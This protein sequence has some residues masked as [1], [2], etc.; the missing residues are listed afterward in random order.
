MS[1]QFESGRC[2]SMPSRAERNP[3]IPSSVSTGLA[4]LSS[5]GVS[6]AT[7]DST[8]RHPFQTRDASIMAPLNGSMPTP[9]RRGHHRSISH[10]FTS[11]FTAIG[12]KREKAAQKH[13]TWDSDSDSD[14]VTYPVQPISTSPRK[15]SKG[16]IGNELAEGRCQTCNSTVRWPRHLKVFRCTSCLMVTDLDPEPQKEVKSPVDHDVGGRARG[17][18]TGPTEQ[19]EQTSSV[20][21]RI[22]R[23]SGIP[24]ASICHSQGCEFA[25]FSRYLLGC[26]CSPID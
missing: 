12:K 1:R 13:I 14:E 8:L 16:G 21:S 7:L 19:A 22:E 5:N 23:K 9:N 18:R 10:P 4:V 11:P 20:P 26:V 2:A 17:A 6:V 25:D 15:E 24:R 3:S